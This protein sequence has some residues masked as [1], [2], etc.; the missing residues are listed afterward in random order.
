MQGEGHE[1]KYRLNEEISEEVARPFGLERSELPREEVIAMLRRSVSE[2]NEW[3]LRYPWEMLALDDEDFQQ[4]NLSGVLL[5]GANLEGTT[6]RGADMRRTNLINA[7]LAFADLAGVNFEGSDLEGADFSAANMKNCKLRNLSAQSDQS[8]LL[9]SDETR[10]ARQ[11]KLKRAYVSALVKAAGYA[12]NNDARIENI[13]VVNLRSRRH[14]L[15]VMAAGNGHC[16]DLVVLANVKAGVEKI[17]Q[18]SQTP[19]GGGFC[20]SG[21]GTDDFKAHTTKSGTIVV[22]VPMDENGELVIPGMTHLVYKWN[23]QT[24]A[25]EKQ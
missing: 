3:R 8:S 4:A 13:D 22:D 5:F 9:K 12:E 6:F 20:H 1:N 16:L 14:S 7:R 18:Q 2:F 25:L 24:Y 23:G 10:W 21:A 19:D 15:L 17:W 11:L